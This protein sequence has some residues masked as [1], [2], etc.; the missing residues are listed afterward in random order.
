MG[1]GRGRRGPGIARAGSWRPA[2]PPATRSQRGWWD[3]ALAVIPGGVDSPVALFAA[4]GGSPFTVA[5]GEG[6]YVFDVEGHRYIDL[7]QSYGAVLLGHA[8]PAGRRG[9]RPGGGRRAPPSACPTP[10]EVRL[11][12]AI[13]ERV[14]GLRAGPP[15]LLGDRGGDERGARWPGGRPGGTGW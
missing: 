15:R 14:P 7:V 4:V 9:H 2:R 11:A 5:R 13:C 12:E 8:H 10:G 1:D 3:R 6:P